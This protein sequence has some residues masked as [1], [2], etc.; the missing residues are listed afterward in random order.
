[1][2]SYG[3]RGYTDHLKK[4]LSLK[5]IPLKNKQFFHFRPVF[6]QLQSREV[7]IVVCRY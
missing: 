1:M 4:Y 2:T 5:K 7:F 3:L 6:F